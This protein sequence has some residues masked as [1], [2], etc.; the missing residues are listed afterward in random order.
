MFN[1]ELDNGTNATPD[2]D[3][4]TSVAFVTASVTTNRT[5]HPLSKTADTNTSSFGVRTEQEH[6]D[7]RTTG[8][9][10]AKRAL[11]NKGGRESMS[12]KEK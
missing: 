6:E 3:S 4:G 12:I 1:N 8:K 9:M 5:V 11:D 7:P 2:L 10:N